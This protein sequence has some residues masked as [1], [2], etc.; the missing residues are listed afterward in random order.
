MRRDG[1]RRGRPDRRCS[2]R[3]PLL[4]P[5]RHGR[6]AALS[7][8]AHPAPCDHQGGHARPGPGRPR[9]AAAHREC[10]CGT[11]ARRHMAADVSGER[12]GVAAD[13]S[14]GAAWRTV[15]VTALLL[16]A[17]LVLVVLGMAVWI[18]VARQTVAAVMGFIV[19]G[20]L[21]SLVW[22]RLGAPD[23]A[24]T[25]AAIGGGLGGVLMLS[26]AGRLRGVT[27]PAREP[28]FARR[29]IA[30]A[31]SAMVAAGLMAGLLLLPE[32]APTLAPAA[33][34]NAAATT[35]GNPVTNVLMAF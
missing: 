4:L 24:L 19:Y 3:R 13:R 14:R 11:E 21:L 28:G 25:E 34:A 30:A 27:Q 9:S 22:L 32:P 16:D 5:G 7:R 2:L 8:C 18:V 23:V 17:G 31:L 10:D 20:L 1:L 33:A 12:L 6:A 29:A 35:L 15:G 26:A